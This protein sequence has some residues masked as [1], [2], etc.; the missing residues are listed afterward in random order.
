MLQKRPRKSPS[1]DLA[2]I[3]KESRNLRSKYYPAY[4]DLR[5][6]KCVVVGGGGVAERKVR[7]LL[8]ADAA[9]VVISPDLTAALRGLVT[10]GKIRHI[11]RAYRKGDLKDAFLVIAATADQAVN[12]AVSKDAP[13]LI[14]VVD[15]PD[16]A[17]FIV[18]A[19]IRSGPLNISVSTGGAS[20]AIASSVR[21]EIESLYDRD[22]G[23]YLSFLARLRKKV[24]KD[25]VDR[26]S[27]ESF[28]RA[29]GSAEMLGFIRE[30]GFEKA[31]DRIMDRLSEL[32]GIK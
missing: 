3:A 16:L 19:V 2:R 4:L 18:P 21:K 25:I 28:F 29:A 8:D 7:S 15:A 12:D 17:N 27:R 30:F 1:A 22:F 6:K 11:K 10:K 20:P 5:R 13:F 31:R 14:N 9:V 23:R 24:M 32:R 26:A